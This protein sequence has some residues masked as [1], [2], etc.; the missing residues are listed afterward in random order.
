[1]NTDAISGSE[2]APSVV[3]D[4]LD[5]ILAHE[6]ISL[7]DVDENTAMMSFNLASI[8][9]VTLIIE[10]EREI[11][12][13]A[14]FPPERYS[15]GSFINELVDI[16][17]EK[18]ESLE[19]TVDSVLKNGYISV[20]DKGELRAEMPS[21]MMVGFLDNMFP[22]MQG[23]NLVAFV[24]QMN[25]EVNSGRKNLE[26]AKESFKSTLKSRGVSV[27]KDKAA[28][29]A[30][31]IVSGVVATSP[32]SLEISKKLKK[33]NLDRLSKLIKTRRQRSQDTQGR[34]KIKDVFDK[35]P[36][37]E[38]I[39]AQK[40]ELIKAEEA[41]KKAVELAKK[42]AEKD[43]Q[44]REA[45]EAVKEAAKQLAE[46]ER[47]EKELLIAQQEAQK[48]ELKAQELAVKEAEIAQKEAQL[49]DLEERL[50]QAEEDRLK[51]EADAAAKAQEKEKKNQSEDDEDIESR[52]AAFESELA[53]PC[54]LCKQ[55][56]VVEK[57]TEKGK[58]FF[59]C[60][61][62]ECR[63]VSWDKPYHFECPLCKNSFL[64]EID[65]GDGKKGLKCPRATCSY[66][67]GN[68]F[69][70]KQNVAQAVSDSGGVR[71]KKKVVR[72][73]RH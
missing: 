13:Y 62:S 31:E 17:L 23:M 12:Q 19:E 4:Q 59:S 58:A 9:C 52:I 32:Q 67:Q 44:I 16:G 30:S 37:K 24:L 8:S 28:E 26:L 68:L 50:R 39:Q 1:M 25:D 18:D 63:F 15:K 54:P 27:S 20:D 61:S 38:E 6:I 47:R 65:I 51:R 34:L 21:F 48:A 33:N 70:P 71:K 10:R 53:M 43:E 41:A 22:G 5:E 46:I 57:T 45:E 49:K 7:L 11:K 14:D 2:L 55:G 29:K 36:S 60:S 73:K 66:T 40:E 3:R 56:E 35:G 64:T 72:R 42:L 69:D